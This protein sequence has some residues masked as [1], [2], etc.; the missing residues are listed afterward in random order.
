MSSAWTCFSKT[1]GFFD[2]YTEQP[3]LRSNGMG[4]F[5]SC[6]GVLLSFGFLLTCLLL[7]VPRVNNYVKGKYVEQSIMGVQ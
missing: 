4:R 7:F 3:K 2:V 6:C 5:T 1:F